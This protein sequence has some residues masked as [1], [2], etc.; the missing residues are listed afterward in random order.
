LTAPTVTGVTP[1][2]RSQGAATNTQIRVT[3]SEPIN[4]ATLNSSNF[5][6]KEF[7]PLGQFVSG[8]RT[9]DT[10]TNTAIFT[11]NVAFKNHESY[12]VTITPGVTDVAGNAVQ[13]Q[14]Q[15]CWT[16]TAGDGTIISLEGFWSGNDACLAGHWHLPITQIGDVLS[17]RG[18]PEGSDQDLCKTYAV[19]EAGRQALGGASCRPSDQPPPVL[20]EVMTVSLT[21]SVNGSAITFTW[22]TDNG[23][24]FTFNGTFSAT[25]G[26][27]NPYLTGV[28]S[29]ATLP[30][31]G[32]NWERQGM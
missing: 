9:F 17:W 4:P 21:G 11:P 7:L 13:S 12:T 29:G 5:T 27:A 23:L 25:T 1:A 16:P 10:S 28:I 18:C 19:T 31:V 20:C 8:T 6:V 15:S 26:N 24:T 3:F 2:N 22:T 14:F 30:A 32:I